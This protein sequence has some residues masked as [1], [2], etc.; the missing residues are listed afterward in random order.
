[1]RVVIRLDKMLDKANMTQRELARKTEIRVP[2]I[3]EM[4]HNQTVRLPLDNL[5]KIC[6]VLE[7]EITDI[8]ELVKEPTE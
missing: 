6:E 4:Y 5:A 1:M 2:S 3:N 7:C 8:L